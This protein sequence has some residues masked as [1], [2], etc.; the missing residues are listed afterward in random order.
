MPKKEDVPVQINLTLPFS[1]RDKLL[2]IADERF[3]G[4][5]IRADG[6]R[7]TYQ[8]LI[9]EAIDKEYALSRKNG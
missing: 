9:R 1:W 6:K 3:S 5:D 2:E 7:K 4:K 8:D